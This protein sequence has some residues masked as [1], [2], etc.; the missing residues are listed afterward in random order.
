MPMKVL[1]W[2][3][4]RLLILD[5]TKLPQS[6]EVISCRKLEQVCDAIESLSIRGAPSLGVT[7]A[8]AVLLGAKN[9][10]AGD[11]GSLLSGIDAI[12]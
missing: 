3:G 11:E 6:E 9:L 10:N 2:T 8:Y 4:D 7:A 12:C 5:Q 1:E